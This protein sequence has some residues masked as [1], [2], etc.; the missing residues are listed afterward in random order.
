VAK[1]SFARGVADLL[2]SGFG[3]ALILVALMIMLVRRYPI[4][5][6]S[7]GIV[8][9]AF[10]RFMKRRSEQARERR[11]IV[12]IGCADRQIERH[13]DA[14][15]SYFRQSVRADLFGNEDKNL[16]RR[17]I[18]T[19]L[20][21]QVALELSSR[22]IPM[23]SALA[24]DLAMHVDRVVR[25][26]LLDSESR[27]TEAP[28][29]TAI[30]TALDYEQHC[31]SVLSQAGW[32]V[33]PTPAT[34]DHGADVIAEKERERLVVQCKLYSKPVGNKAVQEVYSARPLYNC[35][36]A[37]VVAPAGFTAHAQR[38]AQSLGVRL[39]H[40]D[41]LCSFAHELVSRGSARAR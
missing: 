33:R 5:L 38:A 30:I 28:I 17:H 11:R 37:C 16:W 8:A 27:Q 12:A 13:R 29:D 19:F 41:E 1:R 25:A 32:T 14:L 18:D 31:A 15:I 23:D 2:L 6:A 10:W 9:F 34:G 20:K 24:A 36:H 21:T 7:F 22:S 40:H 39:L 26:R 35:D 4:Q 3:I